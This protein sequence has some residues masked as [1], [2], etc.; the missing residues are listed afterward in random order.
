MK[1][2]CKIKKIDMTGMKKMMAV[3][4]QKRNF[5]ICGVL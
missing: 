1:S 5:A 3:P 2:Q 4:S